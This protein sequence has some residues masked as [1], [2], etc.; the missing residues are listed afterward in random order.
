MKIT[1][2][3]LL[4]I[5]SLCSFSMAKETPPYKNPDLPVDVRVKDLLSRMTI[6]EKFWQ[7]Y[8]MP[9]DLDKGKDRFSHGIFGFQVH[10]VGATDPELR[11][12]LQYNP[13]LTAKE[14]AKKINEIQRY[15][16]EETRLGI[17]II[18]FDEAL[19]GLIRS[20]A[21]AF[22]QSIALAATFDTTLMRNISHAIAMETKTRGI[23]QILSPVVNLAT[24][25][26]WGRT[27]ET[28]GEDPYL[29][30]CMGVN[31]VK[32]F[33][34]M[35]VITTPKHFAVNSGDGGRDSNPIHFTE[36]FLEETHLIP[37]KACFQEGNSQSVMTAYNMLDGTP[38]TA[39]SWL[40]IDKLRGEW[41]F[42]GFTIAD[43][44]AVGI[45]HKLH[46][47][48]NNFA[49]AG[50]DAI[51]GGLDV[52]FQTT[53]EEHE[54]FLQACLNGLV[55]EEALDRAAGQVLKAKFR[56]G[57]F[58]HP[59]IDESDAER[60]NACDE[61]RQLAREA[62]R[63]SIVLL[64]NEKQV[65]PLSKQTKRIALIGQ[66]AAEAR[67]GGYSGP[68][69]N[70]VSILEGLKNKLGNQAV[71]HYEE[72]CKRINP[73]YLTVPS[74]CLFTSDGQPGLE[75][76]YFNNISCEGSPDLK[77]I[78][79][80]VQFSWTLFAPD[81]CLAVDWFSVEWKGKLKAPASGTFQLGLEGNDGYQLTVDG[82]VLVDRPQKTSFGTTLVPFT[83]EKDKVYDIR[84]RFYENTKNAR[85]RLVWDI[86]TQN[87]DQSIERAVEAARTSDIAIIVAGIEEGEFRDRGYLTLPGRQEE[88]IRKVAATGK[89]TIVILIGGSAIVMSEWLD[90]VPAVLNAWYPGVEGGNA[91]ADVLFGDY[92]PSGK[93]PI[94]YPIDEAQLPL[95]YSHKPTGRSDDYLNL[96]GEPLFPFG[97][98]LSYSEFDYSNLKVSKALQGTAFHVSFSVKNKGKYAANEVV[99]L[100]I[101]D[102]I[103]SV[104]Q[105]IIRLIHFQPVSLAPNETKE[106]HFTV[107][108]NDL[109][110]LDKEMNR[111]IEP[112]DFRLMIG[113]SCK[114]IR[115]K[116]T[117]TV[118]N[119][120]TVSATCNY[121]VI[122]LPKS[123][124]PVKD[125]PFTLNASTEIRY[126]K[127]NKKLKQTA[128][129]LSE[130]ILEMTGIRTDVKEG[131]GKANCINLTLDQNVASSPEGYRLNIGKTN[132]T[133]AGSSEAGVF[134]GIQML[135]KSMPATHQKEISFPAVQ[136]ADEPQFRY[137]GM[138][139]DVGRH[140]FPTDFI[141]KYIDI[142]ALHNLNTFHWHLTE[143]QGWRIE[144]KKYP[145][146]TEIGSKRKESL[147]N[148]GSGKFDGK[149]YGGF[150]TQKEVQDIIEY[151]AKRYITIIPEID[152]PGHITSALAAYPELGCTGG[153]YE[154][155]TTYGVHK[156]VL[157]VGN[158]QSLR[159]AKDV[160]SE[161]IKLFPS[162]YIHVGGD[163][164]PRDRWEQCP[165]CQALIHKNGWKDTDE[166][167][168]EDKLQSYFMTEIEKFVNSKGRQIIGWDEIL[169]GGL[170]P[171]ATVMSWRGTENGIKAA[172]LQHDVVM[173]P[174]GVTYLS[175]KQLL[176]LGGNR[177]IRRIYDFKVRPDTLPEAVAK[178][179]IG[180]QAC[181][182]SERVDTPER[183][184]YLILPRLSALS[185]LAWADPKQHD[186]EA[187]MD[188]LYRLIP[189]YD[190]ADYT[191]SKHA[192]EITENFCTDTVNG[193]LQVS[194]STI[195]H[196][197]I[198]YTTDGSLPNTTSPIYKS[199][200]KIQKDTKL[201]AIVI[202]PKDTS[203]VFEEQIRVN[204]ATF[205][206]SWLAGAP[207]ENYTFNGVSTL[208]DGLLGNQ[209]YNTGRWLGFLK[210]MDLTIDLQKPTSVSSVSLTVNVS[211]GAAV[212]DAIGL[213]VWCSE[214]GKDY[215]KLAS[216]S[217]PV[218]GKE[219]KDGIYPHS[220]TFPEV[221]TRYIRIVA[222]RTPELPAWH[223]WP[224]NP[225]FLFVDEVCV[226]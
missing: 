28:Y 66:D 172:Q 187:F 148:D 191:Y 182:W 29:S 179:I 155:A 81:S 161:I 52:I 100:Y 98:G 15:F 164:C 97:Y 208:T 102:Q 125:A 145:K 65:L 39:N 36:R 84:I 30:A 128:D 147:L 6:E 64:K 74:S 38:C 183:A 189:V 206:P 104:T 211:K 32:S 169:E 117:L 95:N 197:P 85:I 77:R 116:T 90:Q 195:G 131:T 3:L 186:F 57:L 69:V 222:K 196:R 41:G 79:K 7:T 218:L 177:G 134:Y 115:L 111:I 112:G 109:S 86:D 129:F 118:D 207:H 31:F 146:L 223:M 44:D 121:D 50:A 99:Q 49:E 113:R 174:A 63:K 220:L 96:T 37:F 82:K 135:R 163:E 162:H 171:N 62:A 139:L 154:V 201:K 83:F 19:H 17:P 137:R 54:P 43:A 48:V 167:K 107:D 200:L 55:T 2:L 33:E 18:A 224:G 141:K 133:L 51:N 215:R 226:E 72:G 160:L 175:S 150:Y 127:G 108:E 184:E 26:R 101:R 75:G 209:N 190:K 193:A 70:K 45:I 225:A 157:C 93:L 42:D 205:K 91:V 20:G 144:I 88:L 176:E 199:P 170:A 185:E 22:P 143:D 212:M 35:G 21:T 110:M 47:T 210:D 130:Y 105:P 165:K 27:E 34:E 216:A 114:D 120:E 92:N 156:E 166:H 58:E 73:E 14:M 122:P 136:I 149:P 180:V 173:T 13:K 103:A 221:E 188:R 67:L 142:L 9:G 12:L 89:P 4:I 40:L 46:H 16:V 198:H 123:I 140:F 192:F 168:A 80:Q 119:P 76:H 11:Q 106:L 203:S 23:R 219:D 61:H 78:D 159:F 151:A 202:T 132:I 194:L 178:H 60:W 56:L 217:Y 24:D 126:P 53:Y 181:L 94:T 204:K 10:T 158:E 152:L 214:D 124:T 5:I 59:Y 1:N 25:V 213:E 138:H 153:P 87:E 8:M 68:G 71:I